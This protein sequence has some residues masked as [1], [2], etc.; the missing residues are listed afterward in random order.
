MCDYFLTTAAWSCNFASVPCALSIF[1]AASR[2]PPDTFTSPCFALLSCAA[3]VPA[4]ANAQTHA[5]AHAERILNL[6]S[7]LLIFKIAFPTR[8]CT[9]GYTKAE[10]R[11]Q[12]PEVSSCACRVIRFR[13]GRL[14]AQVF[15]DLRPLASA[16]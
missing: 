9:L 13:R 7:Q 5:S 16:F 1:A 15:T 4:P 11:G 6:I 2:S 8:R 3:D 14:P 10:A 12:R